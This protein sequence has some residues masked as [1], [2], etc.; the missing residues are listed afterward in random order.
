MRRRGLNGAAA[1]AGLEAH[2]LALHV[3]AG[4]AEDVEDLVIADKIHAG[5]LEDQIGIV[6]DQGQTFFSKHIEGSELALDI[7]RSRRFGLGRA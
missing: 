6:F 2:A 3:A 7:G 4:S 1:E 5:L